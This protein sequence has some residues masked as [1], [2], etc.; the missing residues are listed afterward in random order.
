MMNNELKDE[1][2]PS[3]GMAAT[4]CYAP[5]SK[6]FFKECLK[7]IRKQQRF[8]RECAYSIKRLYPSAFESNLIYDNSIVIE[9]LIKVL[10]VAFHDNHGHSWI[11]YFIW[12]L[13]FGKKNKDLKATDKDGNNIPLSNASD[14]YN[15]LI[16]NMSDEKSS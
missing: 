16:K 14:L 13:D 9:Q 3:P 1:L 6:K 4:K 10:K 11:D 15:L 2:L 5:F 8:D 7:A 12:E